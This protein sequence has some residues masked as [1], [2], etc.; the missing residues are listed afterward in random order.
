MVCSDWGVWWWASSRWNRAD[1]NS[2]PCSNVLPL[3]VTDIGPLSLCSCLCSRN[4]RDLIFFV[5]FSC[6]DQHCQKSSK[7]VALGEMTERWMGSQTLSTV[8]KDVLS[9]ERRLKILQLIL[10]WGIYL[11]LIHTKLHLSGLLLSLM[12]VLVSMSYFFYCLGSSSKLYP[13][14]SGGSGEDTTQSTRQK[15]VGALG[16]LAQGRELHSEY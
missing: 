1:D 4:I 8:T 13:P 16:S 15:P 9:W 2:L 7:V 5:L 14:R 10:I 11:W 12:R 3:W 6:K